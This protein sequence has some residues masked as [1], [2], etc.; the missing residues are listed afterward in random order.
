MFNLQ[1]YTEYRED[2]DPA[3]P[4]GK[5]VDT[6][7]G[8]SIE[9]TQ[10]DRR[11]FNTIWGFFQSII[12][13]AYNDMSLSGYPDSID[14][15]ELLTALLVIIN[16][17]TGDLAELIAQLRIDLDNE[18]AIR[19]SQIT[20]L[21]NAINTLSMRVTVVENAIYSDIITNPFEI[22]FADLDGVILLEG[23]WNETS[24]RIE[25]TY[26]DNL[27]EIHFMPGDNYAVIQ[28][29]LNEEFNRVEC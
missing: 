13:H 9:G 28:G 6:P 21:N 20:A 27:I 26:T 17:I 22:T 10:Y 12:H 2:G 16:G 4:A 19:T 3:Y 24:E 23:I 25:V 15:P 7:E 8:D 29:T 5:A 1:D 18:I 11:F 14:N